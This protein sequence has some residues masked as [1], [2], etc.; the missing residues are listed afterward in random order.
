MVSLSRRTLLSGLAFGA[1]GLSAACRPAGNSTSDPQP[2][3]EFKVGV[4][5]T[6]SALTPLQN[7]GYQWGQMISFTLY[8]PLIELVEGTADHLEGVIA[9]SWDVSDPNRI[10]LKIRRGVMFPDGAEL[11]PQDV[12]YSLQVRCDPELVESVGSAPAIVAEQFDSLEIVGD[13]VVRLNT[14]SRVP[15]ALLGR[16]VYALPENAHER[17]NLNTEVVGTGPYRLDSFVGGSSLTLTE[18][19]DYWGGRP[20]VPNL[21]FDLFKDLST[22]VAA[23]RAGTI[24]A[25]YDVKPI[26]VGSVEAVEG[27][28]PVTQGQ[29]YLNWINQVGKGPLVEP[30]ARRALRYCLDMEQ[31][32]KV[33][34]PA[35]RGAWDMF[36]A[37]EFAIDDQGDFSYDPDRARAELEAAGVPNPTIPIHVAGT[38]RDAFLQAQVIQQ[39]FQAAG[40]TSEIKTYQISDYISNVLLTGDWDGIAF[41]AGTIPFPYNTLLSGSVYTVPPDAPTNDLDKELLELAEAGADL[42]P[43]DPE[44]AKIFERVQQV[45][46]EAAGLLVVFLAP[47]TTYMPED[48]SGLRVSGYGDVRWTEIAR[49]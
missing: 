44:L 26:D 5:A 7:L 31:L 14:T 40:I 17:Y 13:D 41:N 3:T 18:N 43:D 47:S 20:T 1:V 24:D 16:F 37:T 2:L 28:V 30:A 8:D 49:V 33:A 15:L 19:P 42:L 10:D 27:F 11:T 46:L 38:Y 32:V 6:F 9:E 12:L 23:L 34:M 4:Q 35:G 36:A 21:R 29:Y 48:V 25:I 22:Q 45:N 39:G